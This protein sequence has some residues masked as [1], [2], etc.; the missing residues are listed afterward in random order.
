MDMDAILSEHG[1]GAVVIFALFGAIAY[2]GRWFLN[3]YSYKLNHRFNESIRE[4]NEIRDEV[5][6]SNNKLYGITEKLIS[7]QRLIQEDINAI[8]SSLDTL[9]KY[10][11]ASK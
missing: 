7:N 1:I 5:I 9:L 3:V 11:K 4:I 10:I 8:E 6:E 2:F